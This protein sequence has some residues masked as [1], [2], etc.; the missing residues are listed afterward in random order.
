MSDLKDAL[1]LVGQYNEQE[2]ETVVDEVVEHQQQKEGTLATL[3]H[4][5]D[6]EVGLQIL[7][8][9]EGFGGTAKRLP[10]SRF[11]SMVGEHESETQESSEAATILQ[12][13]S[14]LVGA[15][16]V[17]SEVQTGG[18]PGSGTALKKPAKQPKPLDVSTIIKR[19]RVSYP[20]MRAT[21][22]DSILR[23]LLLA[24]LVTQ[25]YNEGG[26]IV[27][28]LG[29]TTSSLP[30]DNFTKYREALSGLTESNTPAV[31]AKLMEIGLQAT[32]AGGDEEVQSSMQVDA[33]RAK[34]LREVV[35]GLL[36]GSTSEGI[37]G[38]V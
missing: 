10:L 37:D 8:Y 18:A 28:P 15:T 22:V 12:E 6:G 20:V 4:L 38:V 34:R 35:V 24:E 21:R 27:L 32:N 2:L 33:E 3:T 17:D 29:I 16:T 36:L 25:V 13:L 23:Q 31:T 5:E 30:L 11:A 26:S 19:M 9:D 1:L 14:S 7:A